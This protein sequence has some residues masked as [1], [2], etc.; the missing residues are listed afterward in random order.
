M[1]P[2][3]FLH[4]SNPPPTDRVDKETWIG[5]MHLPDHVSITTSNHHGTA[6]KQLYKTWRAWIEAIGQDADPLFDTILDACDEYEAAVFNSLHGYYRTAIGGLR[7]ALELATIGSY[8]QVCGKPLEFAEWRV[9]SEKITFRRACDGLASAAA[10]HTLENHLATNLNDT[11]FG[12]KDP[13]KDGGWAR[14]TYD[15]L[16]TYA[17]SRPGSTHGDLWRSN[18]PIY[19][20]EA[21]LLA[22]DLY[23][24]TSALSFIL[25]KLGRPDFALPSNAC[26]LFE[27]SDRHWSKIALCAHE[28]LFH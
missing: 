20:R 17:H 9:G 8:A 5:I 26:T 15:L 10:V 18:G 14:R 27:N 19:V 11:L 25:V 16:C 1:D 22:T 6:L 3:L 23:L 2:D 12:G 28:L 21:F 7:N 4:G 24:E 13:G